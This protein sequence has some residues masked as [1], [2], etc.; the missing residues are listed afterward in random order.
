[1]SPLWT[2]AEIVAATGGRPE[3]LLDGPVN[4]VSIDSRDIQPE[5]LFVAIKGDS[6]DGHDFVRTA[7]DAGAAAALVSEER[8][9][10]LG[11]E[12]LIVVPDPLRALQALAVAARA[13]SRAQFIAITGSVGKTSTKEAVRTALAAS[14]R[15][16]ASIKSY[17]NHWGV[18]LMLASMP[19]EAQFGVFEIGMNHAGEITELVRMVRP[20]IAVVTLVAPAHLEFFPSVT[21]IAEAKAEILLGLE[22]GGVALLNTD[23]DYLH[24]LMGAARALRITQVVTYGFDESADWHIRSLRTSGGTSF[25]QVEHEGRTMTLALQVPGRHMIAN[26]VAA[27]AVSALSGEGTAAALTALASF[28]APEGRGETRR[29]G[30]PKRPLLLVDESYNANTASMRAAMEVFSTTR[31]PG[32]QKVLVLGDMLELGAESAA[33]HA[34][35]VD[36]VKATGAGRIYLVGTGM[37]ALRDAL[38]SE[39]VT[40]HAE[41]VEELTETILAGLAPGDAVMVKGSKGVRLAGLVGRIRGQFA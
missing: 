6:R 14:G 7:L 12:R 29:L 40:A 4:S 9:A 36:A 8:A 34:S 18:P 3:G 15:V 2:I 38:G 37:A 28:A 13:R 23:H 1:M 27:L 32:G 33:L 5:A 41:S 35:L 39:R 10:E 16:H 31:P 25:A 30:D 19:R 17:N 22:P 11:N 21:A 26:A 20:H 24:V